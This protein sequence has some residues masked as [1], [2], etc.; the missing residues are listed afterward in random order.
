MSTRATHLIFCPALNEIQRYRQMAP[1]GFAA[2]MLNNKVPTWLK[3]EH[4]PGVKAIQVY[5][6]VR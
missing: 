1:Q 2:Q 4:V 5:R 6:I 3:R